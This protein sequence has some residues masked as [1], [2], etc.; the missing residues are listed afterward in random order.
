[1]S[2]KGAPRDIL[3]YLY[4]MGIWFI[5]TILSIFK[6]Y[7]NPSG[8]ET[9]IFQWYQANNTAIDGFVTQGA[10]KVLTL[11]DDWDFIFPHKSGQLPGPRLNIKTVFPRYGDSHV[12]DK[13]VVRPSY[14]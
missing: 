3:S 5:S 7:I 13:T 11:Q 6:I 4:H 12:K 1:M 8:V 14:L 10:I 2:V 9:G